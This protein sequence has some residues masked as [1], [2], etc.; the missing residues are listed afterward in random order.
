M[1]ITQ[2][3]WQKRSLLRSI[4]TVT[5]SKIQY[6]PM[7]LPS[8]HSSPTT[9]HPSPRSFNMDKILASRFSTRHAA[10]GS[11]RVE[12]TDPHS[13]KYLTDYSET[14][15]RTLPHKRVVCGVTR[16]VIHGVARRVVCR[17]EWGGAGITG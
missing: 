14:K 5:V 11:W 13:A 17:L 12:N 16:R 7:R 9:R 3:G 10:Q 8:N 15:L 2:N 6:F 4:I 1:A